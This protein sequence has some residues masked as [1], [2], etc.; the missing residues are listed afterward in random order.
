MIG[1]FIHSLS[2]IKNAIR[3]DLRHSD[4]FALS[5][6][7]LF[8]P[9]L[10]LLT[11]LESALN[12][13]DEGFDYLKTQLPLVSFSM[14]MMAMATTEHRTA[15]QRG[16]NQTRDTGSGSDDEDGDHHG[17][18]VEQ[19]ERN[20]PAPPP[21]KVGWADRLLMVHQDLEA[22]ISILEKQTSKETNHNAKRADED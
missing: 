21:V 22:R 3:D 8:A 12:V 19:V 4:Y 18:H 10:L 2:V 14:P 5:L 15:G 7:V 1:C 6:H 13:M 16:F 11:P 9:L 17:H 20:E